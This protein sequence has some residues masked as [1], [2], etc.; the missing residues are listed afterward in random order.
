MAYVISD[1]C[2][3]CGSCAEENIP[4]PALQGRTAV[5]PDIL[6]CNGHWKKSGLGIFTGT[7]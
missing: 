3:S 6:K 5:V 2:I 1:A 7:K 4:K